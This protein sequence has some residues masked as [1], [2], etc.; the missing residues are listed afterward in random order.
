MGS[1]CFILLAVTESYLLG[2]GAFVLF[3]SMYKLAGVQVDSMCME[4]VK[5]QHRGKYFHLISIKPLSSGLSALV[6]GYI[7]DAYGYRR[8][9]VITGIALFVCPTPPLIAVVR[10]VS[11]R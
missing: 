2:A 8:A 11:R 1:A 4:T 6:G 9:L 3:R 7:I 10:L 5:P